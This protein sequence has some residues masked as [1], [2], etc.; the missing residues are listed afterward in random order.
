MRSLLNLL[1]SYEAPNVSSRPNSREVDKSASSTPE[2]MSQAWHISD[3]MEELQA[4]VGPS[5][6]HIGR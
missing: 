5:L 4:R 3:S 2:A 1:L 6:G